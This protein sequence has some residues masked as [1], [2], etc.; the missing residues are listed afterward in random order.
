MINRKIYKT[1]P[2]CKSFFLHFYQCISTSFIFNLEV[3][4]KSTI[5]CAWIKGVGSAKSTPSGGGRG[6]QGHT[7][8]D[9]VCS[10]L[11]WREKITKNVKNMPSLTCSKICFK[12]KARIWVK[13]GMRSVV[14]LEEWCDKPVR[15]SGHMY[16][17]LFHSKLKHVYHSIFAEL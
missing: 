8:R 13:L 14:F 3:K 10:S 12:K 9:V 17:L 1:K 7:P 15:H 4:Q 6:T 11:G 16:M 2:T 5:G